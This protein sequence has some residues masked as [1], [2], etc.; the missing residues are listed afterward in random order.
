MAIL[1]ESKGSH[2]DPSLLDAFELIA[3]K[4]YQH[5]SG[6]EDEGLREEVL[7]ITQYYFSSGLD[8]LKYK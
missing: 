3:E 2:F 7:E 4:L 8:S 6:R 1:H 5:L